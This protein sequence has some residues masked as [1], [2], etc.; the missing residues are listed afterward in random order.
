MT[1]KQNNKSQLHVLP[2]FNGDCL[3]LKTFD[4]SGNPFTMLIDGGTSATFHPVLKKEIKQLEYIDLVVL[5]HIDSDH[6]GGLIKYIKSPNFDHEKVGQFWLNSKNL[7][8]V[9]D[10]SDISYGQAKTLEELL[11]DH[12]VPTEKIKTDIYVGCVPA[13]PNGIE[14]ELLSPTLEV[15]SK[16]EE[17]WPEL[18]DE[19]KDK[20]KTL[21]ISGLKPSQIPRGDLLALASAEDT[22]QKTILGD[23][24]N[25][26]SI[27]F[28]LRSFDLKILFLADSHPHQIMNELDKTYSSTNRLA[29]DLVKVSHHGSK[30]NTMKC[31]LDVLD[32][33]RYIISTNGGS[34]DD[35]HPDRETIARII[36]HPE[37][38][39]DEYKKERKIYL[40]Y[41]LESIEGKAG[42]F[43]EAEDF[44]I[45][46]WQLLEKTN[47]FEHE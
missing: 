17:R 4:R 36:H 46:N 28:V 45:G 16:L 26:S 20:L 7:R 42:K 24:V 3:I 22:P 44:K 6:I 41:P 29:V 15:L 43:I 47:I 13:L 30:N 39:R 25:S 12:Q 31:V 14:I 11:I 40:N 38:A 1:I 27:A 32:C 35:T 9:G 5:T 37:R 18:S 33:D 19:Y 21:Q 23:I 8:F 2:A 10:G 34:S